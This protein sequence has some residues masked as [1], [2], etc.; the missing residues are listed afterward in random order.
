MT[1]ELQYP[2]RQM[3]IRTMLIV[4]LF[5][6]LSLGQTTLGHLHW[7]LCTAASMWL[8]DSAH[9]PTQGHLKHLRG[10][11]SR[12]MVPLQEGLPLGLCSSVCA[13]DFNILLQYCDYCIKPSRKKCWSYF[14]KEHSLINQTQLSQRKRKIDKIIKATQHSRSLTWVGRSLA[15]PACLSL[16]CERKE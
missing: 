5:T 13:K 7:S 4:L 3:N 11:A 15:L 12:Q 10:D 14:L 1:A 2:I 6:Y 16:N 8:W 9:Q